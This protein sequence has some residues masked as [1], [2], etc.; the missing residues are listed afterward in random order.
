MVELSEPTVNCYS[1]ARP[2]TRGWVAGAG[3]SA[4]KEAPEFRSFLA[5]TPAPLFQASDEAPVAHSAVNSSIGMIASSALLWFA[6]RAPS[7]E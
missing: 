7:L 6:P 5:P 1:R 2:E 3:L 4:A